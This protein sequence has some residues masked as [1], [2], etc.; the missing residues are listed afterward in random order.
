MLCCTWGNGVRVWGSVSGGPRSAGLLWSWCWRG[1]PW[2]VRSWSWS[3]WSRSSAEKTPWRWGTA[4][5]VHCAFP[6]DARV[7]QDVLLF[8]HD[9]V[10]FFRLLG[11]FCACQFLFWTYLAHTAFYSLRST[12]A[13]RP[14]SDSQQGERPLPTLPGGA[15]LN[16]GSNK[17]RFG[18]TASCLT[19]GCLILVAGFIFSRRSV[20]RV[21]LHRGGQE[22]T[23]TTY[24]PF[25]LPSSFTVPL[26]N[27]SCMSHRSEVPAM[28]PLKIK[29][30]PFYFLL[31]KQGR[32][33]NAKLFDITVGAYRKV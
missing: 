30:R 25:G 2:P 23:L 11:L 10:R 18:F 31:D 27:I 26:R 16:V 32:I 1:A 22:V 6:L 17:W 21:I 12:G 24:Y 9:R 7:A 33:T 19:V 15:T 13:K 29:G 14:E 8:Q 20:S 3:A 28:I 5:R 4:R